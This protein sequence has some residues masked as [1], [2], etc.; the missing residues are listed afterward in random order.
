MRL[1]VALLGICAAV[2]GC[3]TGAAS[4][5]VAVSP[6]SKPVSAREAELPPGF[7]AELVP[8]PVFDG[9]VFVVEG[10]APEGPV[11]VL[12]HGL[13]DGGARDFY[14]VLG[15]LASRY[16]VLTFDLPGFG[17]STHATELYSPERY[18]EL[19]RGLVRQRH[20][21]PFNLVGHSMGG[22]IALV[23]AARFPGDLD[24]L[25]LI[26]AAGF[27]HRNAFVDFAVAAGLDNVLG[28]FAGPGKELLDST[29]QAAAAA[30]GPLSPTPEPD[31][32]LENALLRK[33]ILRTPTR[34]AALATILQNFAPL[35]AEVKTPTW[36]L[37]G[38]NDP[39]A[40][41]R[42]AKILEAKLP[43]ARLQVLESSG[44]DP[45]ASAPAAVSQFLLEGLV[46]PPGDL[47]RRQ[48]SPPTVPRPGKCAGT[49]GMTFQGDYTEI[50]I[51]GCSAV[52]L[53]GVR[54][55][56]IKIRDS[57]VTIE[58]TRVSSEAVALVVENSK[59]EV[60]A[61]ELEGD[62]AMETTAGD[63]DLAG[64][65]LTGKR[66]SV[67]VDRGSRLIFSISRLSSPLGRRYVHELLEM[68]AGSEL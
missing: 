38:R 22:A 48:P 52:R 44:H 4:E 67:Q 65:T 5:P 16:H 20:A 21:G 46:T 19:I 58:G 50:D 42:T 53:D 28:I 24:R 62:V 31:F 41:L 13:G 43:G 49:S 25:F 23:Y 12:V 10:G 55:A 3:R 14:P 34:I 61:S 64:V 15:S 36:I 27:L 6:E 29:L 7:R 11:V 1:A 66:K 40:S 18:A 47:P 59:V 45:M 35:I 51:V 33:T 30:V 68:G 57:I 60:T 39:I 26:D 54:C 56:S 17:R 63:V 37:W 2:P 32:L 8:A 9:E